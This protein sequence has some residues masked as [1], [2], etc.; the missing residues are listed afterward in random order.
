MSNIKIKSAFCFCCKKPIKVN[1]ETIKDMLE[2]DIDT[3]P[4][5]CKYCDR[6]NYIEIGEIQFQQSKI[7]NH[8]R[9]KNS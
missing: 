1:V 2:I 7:L 6:E 9:K 5:K 4:V 3:L 8:L